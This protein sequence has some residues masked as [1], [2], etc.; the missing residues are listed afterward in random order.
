MDS[1]RDDTDERDLPQRSKCE[2]MRDFTQQSIFQ[3]EKMEAPYRPSLFQFEKMEAPYRQSLFQFEKME[4]PYV[5]RANCILRYSWE[6]KQVESTAQ[7][8]PE[9]RFCARKY[10]EMTEINKRH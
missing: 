7:K 8:A 5:G 1:V 6:H 2:P 3:F 10:E 4:A 9:E